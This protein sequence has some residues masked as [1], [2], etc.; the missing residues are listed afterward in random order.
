ML[1]GMPNALMALDQMG[2]TP[3]FLIVL[4]SIS[5]QKLNFLG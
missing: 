1:K 5:D 3:K 2:E 4:A